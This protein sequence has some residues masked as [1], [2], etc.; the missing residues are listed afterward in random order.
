VTIVKSRETHRKNATN[1]NAEKIPLVLT[2]RFSN[3]P[4]GDLS[5]PPRDV[6]HGLI[7]LTGALATSVTKNDKNRAIRSRPGVD[8]T[9][10]PSPV[11]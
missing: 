4:V 10:S 2:R 8:I 11:V 6:S 9:S 7:C 3:L 5:S 1:R